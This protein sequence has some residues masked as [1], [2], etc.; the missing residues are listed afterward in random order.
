MKGDC[1]ARS[2]DVLDKNNER[3]GLTLNSTVVIENLVLYTVR[4]LEMG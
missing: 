4:R 3:E 2:R 1:R